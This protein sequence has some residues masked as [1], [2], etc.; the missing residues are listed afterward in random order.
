MIINNINSRKIWIILSLF[1]VI[2]HKSFAIQPAIAKLR[3]NSV[4]HSSGHGA[5]NSPISK[6]PTEHAVLGWAT[7]DTVKQSRE[8]E[9]IQ[10]TSNSVVSSSA[11]E[12]HFIPAQRGVYKLK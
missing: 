3:S 10:S 8:I 7:V 5:H 2:S 1:L 9:E 4:D 11:S 6:R 12:P